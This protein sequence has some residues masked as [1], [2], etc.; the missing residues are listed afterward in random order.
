MQQTKRFYDTTGLICVQ[1]ALK[2]GLFHYFNIAIYQNNISQRHSAV[3]TRR[4]RSNTNFISILT[5]ALQ[6]IVIDLKILHVNV[7]AKMGENLT[8]KLSQSLFRLIRAY[9]DQVNGG[10]KATRLAS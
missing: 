9:K 6:M 3:N 5:T 1:T 10:G 7:V 8:C 4:N 2:S